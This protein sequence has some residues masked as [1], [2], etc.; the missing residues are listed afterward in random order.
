MP[1]LPESAQPSM[2][3]GNPPFDTYRFFAVLEKTFPTPTARNLMRATRAL[4]VDRT[5]RVKREGLTIKDLESVRSLWHI[6][7]S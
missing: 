5:G 3:F 1:G 4:L 6:Y 7:A 2:N